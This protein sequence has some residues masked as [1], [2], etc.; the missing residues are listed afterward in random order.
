MIHLLKT[1]LLSKFTFI[2]IF[3]R[4]KNYETSLKNLISQ[5]DLIENS[6]KKI[7]N[8]V[9]KFQTFLNVYL[10]ELKLNFLT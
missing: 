10:L 4:T 7:K 6:R 5:L 2:F 8:A 3:M 9:S 1:T